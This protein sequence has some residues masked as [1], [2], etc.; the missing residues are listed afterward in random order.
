MH[1]CQRS[2]FVQLKNAAVKHIK[3]RLTSLLVGIH[4]FTAT[5]QVGR[6]YFSTLVLEASVPDRFSRFWLIRSLHFTDILPN[7]LVRIRSYSKNLRLLWN[8]R[9]VVCTSDKVTEKRSL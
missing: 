5:F 2:C 4:T 3:N 1:F 7:S 6:P 9:F 8:N